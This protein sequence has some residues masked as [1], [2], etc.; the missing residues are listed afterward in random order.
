MKVHQSSLPIRLRRIAAEHLESIRETQIGLNTK[1]LYLGE[2]VIPIYRADI[3]E[4]AYYE[5]HVFKATRENLDGRKDLLDS[6]KKININHGNVLKNV[7]VT[8]GFVSKEDF[9]LYNR[10]QKDIQGFIIISTDRHDFPI[11]HW[12]L[13]SQPPSFNLMELAL[14]KK[15]S[16][17]KIYKVDNLAYLAEDEKGNEIAVLGEVPK[18]IK[19]MPSDIS[20]YKGIINSSVSEQKKLNNQRYDDS[21]KVSQGRTIK[22]GPKPLDI[23][24]ESSNWIELKK[25]FNSDLKPMLDQLKQQASESWEIQEMIE[26]MGDGI[27]AGKVYNLIP[28]EKEYSVSFSGEAIDFI[29]QRVVK[30]P[31]GYSVVEIQTTQLPVNHELSFT[32]TLNYNNKTKEEVNLF[33]VNSNAP[34]ES[35][36]NIKFEK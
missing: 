7:F 27:I 19:G 4:P 11:N 14:T 23:K 34:S 16:I 32:A 30:R 8:P 15:S 1:D 3:K 12:S 18:I 25:Y 2:D 10:I 31:N 36:S 35:I 26:K 9:D 20:K 24:F 28:L 17:S 6:I 13:E 21:S 5:F 29:K 33:I 22:K